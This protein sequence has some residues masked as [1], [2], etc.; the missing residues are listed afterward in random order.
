[1]NIAKLVYELEKL[2]NESMSK[3]ADIEELHMQ[4]DSLLLSYIDNV[5]VIM[6]FN[7]INKWYAWQNKYDVI[8]Y[9]YWKK[10]NTTWK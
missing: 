6:A 3:H 8:M 9:K 10:G 7:K 5:D 1:M 4:A 2:A